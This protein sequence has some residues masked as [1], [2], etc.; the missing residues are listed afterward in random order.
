MFS[1]NLTLKQFIKQVP[2]CDHSASLE[3]LLTIFSNSQSQIVAVVDQQQSLLGTLQLNSLIPYLLKQLLPQNL[4]SQKIFNLCE[5]SINSL[6]EPTTILKAQTS[7]KEFWLYLQTNQDS[8]REDQ[9]YAV[10]DE[11][12]RFLGFLDSWLLV[13]S[14]L[15]LAATNS[16]TSTSKPI[17]L[18]QAIQLL[19][20][21]PLPLMLES[22]EGEVLCQN[23]TWRS[24]IGEQHDEELLKP[25][26]SLSAISAP[27]P[28]SRSPLT[29][30]TAVNRWCSLAQ[31]RE[32]SLE[33]QNTPSQIAFQIANEQRL[34]ERDFQRQDR[35]HN[36]ENSS[37]HS[38][39]TKTKA[40]GA[41]QFERLPF[42]LHD[43]K[44]SY[45]APSNS[46]YNRPLW[47]VVATDVTEQQQLCKE[48]A[49][50]NA[51]LIQLNRL[52]DEFLACI[53]HELKSP[54]TAVV[55]L[56][57]L[58]KEQRLGEL[59]QR[60]ARYAGLVYQ[61]GRHLMTL[62]N[63]ILD[64]TRLETGQLKLNPDA[65]KIRTVCER[66]YQQALPQQSTEN[67]PGDFPRPQAQFNLEID[68]GLEMIVA[69]ELRLRQMLSHLLD[70][71]LK[72]TQNGGEF[73]L[74]VSLW[75][76]WIAF[77]VWDTGIGIP[78]DSQHLIFQK[79]QQLENPLSRQFEG[80]G[81]GLVLTQRLAHAHG[82]DI[83]FT[84]QP[85]EGSQFTLLLPPTPP[86]NDFEQN[87]E[88]DFLDTNHNRLVLVIEA[89]P[90]YIE[91]STEQLRNLGYRVV[92]ARS[93]TE[94]LEKA[95][96]LQPRAILLNPLLP[97]LS[98]WDVLT[99]L[100]ADRQ[101]KDIPVLVTATRADKKRAEQNNADG[102]LSLPISRQT[103]KKSLARLG[104]L[105]N[106]DL[107]GLTILRLN[108]NPHQEDWVNS[109]FEVAL[110]RY[111]SH[112]NYRILEADD[113][114]QAEIIA[115]VW[116]PDVMLLD[117]LELENPYTYLQ[118]LS[119]YSYIASLPLVTLDHKNTHAANQILGLS[120]FPCLVPSQ[121]RSIPALI[122]V[123]QVAAGMNP[124]QNILVFGEWGKESSAEHLNLELSG[125]GSSGGEW[126]Q[127]LTH[128]LQT[129]GLKTSLSHS[130]TEV[131]S[132][133]EHQ[134]ISLLLLYLGNV[135]VSPGLVAG[136]KRLAAKE[137]KPQIL[138]L[139]CR[140][141]K[142]NTK[143]VD[144]QLESFLENI[145]TKIIRGR[146]QP[147]SKL[148]E[149]IN[150]MFGEWLP[151]KSKIN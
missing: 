98:G 46:K 24:Q 28:D 4:N 26:A 47:L 27:S 87:R 37:P 146:S 118:S 127:A 62:V 103:L 143:S 90:K 89:V 101:T 106:L 114:E 88:Q 67:P 61:S 64:L 72:F 54:L 131:E 14:L 83:S 128:Y 97:L 141:Q 38:R 9:N 63:D 33:Q 36:W 115:R 22:S 1:P 50:K 134:S 31:N 23:Y 109:S 56:S 44:Q 110:S 95:R 111:S 43:L 148:L 105:P 125:L 116:K 149:Q 13:K 2:K 130:W 80:T 40:E 15:P 99:L 142:Q 84:S 93:G 137:I 53:S 71:A 20:Q 74:K 76:G 104:E 57:S 42:Y 85:G 138:L 45:H 19:E 8:L 65:V 34:E 102:F 18:T 96:Q 55:G 25:M 91:D 70:N 117:S 69:D 60:Q 59:N 58:L 132:Q 3:Q 94:A 135:T 145:A 78:A 49:A 82:G 133:I 41:W 81:L 108:P 51:D 52:K 11:E 5:S 66:A 32:A 120:V 77:T 119:Q 150:Q 100:K 86:F 21:L 112:L 113:L 79:F 10:V 12:E 136:L 6:I 147:T 129:A 73:G 17:N 123:I 75:E 151:A 144:S 16:E 92:I 68:P 124:Q 139:D 7:I 39:Q 126:L 48:L 121:E 122:Q 35:F 29:V 107:K 30:G 140:C